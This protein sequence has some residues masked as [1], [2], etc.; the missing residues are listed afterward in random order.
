MPTKKPEP[1]IKL[2]RKIG[3]CGCC[4]QEH[5]E[6]THY[7]GFKMGPNLWLCFFCARLCPT[8]GMTIEDQTRL[9]RVLLAALAMPAKRRKRL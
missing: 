5:V 3:D 4:G 6:V 2:K 7:P 1:K 9:L 8:Q